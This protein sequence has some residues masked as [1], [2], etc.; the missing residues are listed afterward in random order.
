M[1]LAEALAERADLQKR[2]QQLKERLNL[3]AKVQEGEQPNENPEDLL[4]E[5]DTL[6][7]RLEQLITAINK[8][9]SLTFADGESLT[10]LL[11]KRDCL[12]LK[13][14]ILQDFLNEAND[15]F[16]RGTRTEIKICS[17]VSIT[18]K[19]KE[20]DNLSRDLRKLDMRIQQCNWT[21]DLI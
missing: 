20:L 19:R 12:S 6:I 9:N 3:N 21:T 5:L 11:A 10:A 1:K 14:T 18:K 8:T 2:I 17:T 15:I 4:T 16:Y 13:I 7:S